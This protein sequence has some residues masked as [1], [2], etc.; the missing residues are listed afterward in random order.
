MY[1]IS[2]YTFSFSGEGIDTQGRRI[3][4]NSLTGAL[5]MIDAKDYIAFENFEKH[6][7]EIS[8]EKLIKDLKI[9]GFLLEDSVDEKREIQLRLMSGRFNSS[10]LFLTL[11]PTSDCNFRC[12][13]C[14][15]KDVLIDTAMSIEVQDAIINFVESKMPSIKSL[16]ITWYGGEPLLGIDAIRYM[17]KK[18]IQMCEENHVT[19]SA[20][21]ITNGYLLTR[22]IAAE[23]KTLKVSFY[24]ITL[25]GDE[26]THNS[27]RFLV[28]GGATYST[29]LNNI[30]ASYDLLETVSLR[31]NVDKT[32]ISASDNI[33]RVLEK[34]GIGEK[35]KPYL[36][37]VTGE[38][39][40]IQEYCFSTHEF[41]KI[42]LE[43]TKRHQ[44][45][46]DWF[47]SYPGTRSNFCGADSVNSFVINA[48]GLMY[49]CWDDIGKTDRAVGDILD[50]SRMN[51][52]ILY[53][54]MLYDPTKDEQCG[55]CK[56]LPVCMGG[57]P[58]RRTQGDVD[59]CSIYKTLIKEYINYFTH[60]LLTQ[61]ENSK[62]NDP[63]ETEAVKC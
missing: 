30:V 48:D 19:Y 59:N 14:Y 57:C 25:D 8:N 38:N 49:K 61:K 39:P 12:P 21:I 9:G 11:A 35:V 46:I 47:R 36:G 5:A 62:D 29:I 31:V 2:N 1:K 56:L 26:E 7:I 34:Y 32:N 55:K 13:Y 54:Y 6:G 44:E 45:V 43:Y 17:S 53:G 63:I 41:A 16:A 24:Q 18:F 15:E 60:M 50:G 20:G 37:K 33:F 51:D 10:A 23:L 28:G 40:G 58:Y 4:Y 3:L 42:D 52:S 27:R 22:E